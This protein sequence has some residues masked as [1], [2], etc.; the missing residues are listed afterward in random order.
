MGKCR[1]NCLKR[2]SYCCLNFFNA[3]ISSV[4]LLKVT[5]QNYKFYEVDSNKNGGD[6]GQS[7]YL[8]SQ[9]KVL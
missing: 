9:K 8:T 2:S 4:C 1:K 3:A 7:L 6:D 5:G